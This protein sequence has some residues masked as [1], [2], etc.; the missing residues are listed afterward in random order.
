MRP[1]LIIAVLALGGVVALSHHAAPVSA[2]VLLAESAPLSLAGD[3]GTNVL[4]AL[5]ARSGA[6]RRVELEPGQTFSFNAAIGDPANIPVVVVSGVPGGCWCDLAS[7]YAQVTRQ[8]GL[9]P[10]FRNHGFALRDVSIE[11][12][13]SIW[14]IDGTP[15]T[16]GSR[17]DLEITNTTSSVVVL[18][19]D[20]DGSAV[21]VRAMDGR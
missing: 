7:R 12:S 16:D 19:A 11:D 21:V 9:T 15:G 8:V 17:Q 20:D 4:A 18:T 5:S 6:L 13:V 3:C 10:R 1:A 14:N 2:P